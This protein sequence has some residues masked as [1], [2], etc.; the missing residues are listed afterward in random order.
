M[1]A[2]TAESNIQQLVEQI[3]DWRPS[4]MLVDQSQLL[5]RNI[6]LT[7]RESKNGY[8]YSEQALRQ[9]IPLYENKPVFLDHAAN[10]SRP[11]ERST[12]DLAGSIVNP[13][14]ESGRIR[15][16]I[17]LLDA[18]A[19]RTFLAL[20][21]SKSSTV[22]MS[23]VV[24]AQRSRDNSVVESIHDVVSVDAVVYR[25]REVI[26][27]RIDGTSRPIVA[28]V[29]QMLVPENLRGTARSVISSTEITVTSNV[30]ETKFAN[31]IHNIAE[32]LSSPFI[33]EQGGQ[34]INDW[35]IGDFRRQFIW[36]EICT[37]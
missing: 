37:V 20:A 30:N 7:G 15:A 33:D 26:D 3:Q 5:V 16:D 14:F 32:V 12:R 21:E 11:Y 36:T 29:R 31:P 27:D 28:P 18:E 19:G 4:D 9:A 35:Y 17:Q 13:R 23:H 10:I 24:L 22:G 1:T 25:A 34:A 8:Q 2:F 6:A